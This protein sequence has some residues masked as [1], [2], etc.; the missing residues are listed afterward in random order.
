MHNAQVQLVQGWLA[1]CAGMWQGVAATHGC[2]LLVV[3]LPRRLQEAVGCIFSCDALAMHFS[4]AEKKPR[5]LLSLCNG[6][7]PG[8]WSGSGV[9]EG[10]GLW[11]AA[12]AAAAAGDIGSL[13]TCY[14]KWLPCILIFACFSVCC[15]GCQRC[16][17]L[18]C[19]FGRNTAAAVGRDT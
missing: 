12:I 7:W 17:L 3:L 14:S 2:T 5:Q 9:N 11:A 10:G 4:K 1:S 19:C 13:H 15:H 8:K 6:P 18:V 16:L